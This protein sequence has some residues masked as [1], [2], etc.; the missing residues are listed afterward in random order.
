L[1][2]NAADGVH[3]GQVPIRFTHRLAERIIS[4]AFLSVLGLRAQHIHVPTPHQFGY[5]RIAARSE[6]ARSLQLPEFNE[7]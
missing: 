7:N 5:S 1:A 3:N 4:G 6:Q 2:P